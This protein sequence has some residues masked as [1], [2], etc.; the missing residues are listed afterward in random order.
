MKKFLFKL[1]PFILLLTTQAMAAKVSIFDR[2][3]ALVDDDV[4]LNS[5]LDRKIKTF[6]EQLKSSGTQLPD[7][8]AFRNQ[9]LER[10]IL[11][12][13]QLQFAKRAGVRVSDQELNATIA[14]IAASSSKTVDQ[15]QKALVKEGDNYT[16]FREDLRKEIMINRV[17]QGQV[18]RR[19]FISEQEIDGMVQLMD[20]Q[21][22][23][24]TQYHIA[25]IMIAIPE[26]STPAEIPKAS[27]GDT[28]E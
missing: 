11:D 28:W 26:S 17:R 20:E 5:E 8:K 4:I 14:K 3:V 22:K 23:N 19:V 9:V 12:S 13:L 10:L 6:K 27:M 18:G 1:L 24:N 25:H 16:V 15:L 2:I 21:G 7:E